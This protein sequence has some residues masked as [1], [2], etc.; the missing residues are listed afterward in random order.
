[1]A[2]DVSKLIAGCRCADNNFLERK[3]CLGT[4][5]GM[6]SGNGHNRYKDAEDGRFGVAAESQRAV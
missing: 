1:M 4:Y 5:T 6:A 3:R 2:E